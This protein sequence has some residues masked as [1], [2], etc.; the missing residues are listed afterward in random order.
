[1]SGAGNNDDPPAHS[2]PVPPAAPASGAR[3]D[4]RADAIIVL[5]GG[6]HADGSL[7]RPSATRIERAAEIFH[8]GIAPRIILSGR[9]GLAAPEP[10]ITE[11]AAMAARAEELGV[12]AAALLLE[13]ESRD[14]IGNVYFTREMFLEPNG[15]HSVR[16][17][18]S[19]FHLSRAA[20]VFRKILGGSYDFSFV[21]ASSGLSPR[22]L[23]FRSLEECKLSIFL[24]E[25]LEALHDAD[26]HAIDRL[27]ENDHPGYASAPTLS[28]DEMRRRLDEIAHINE[29]A[30]TEHWLAGDRRG[31]PRRGDRRER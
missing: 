21:S 1:V 23:I 24:N 29:I 25:W 19:D 9:C 5:G 6:V 20:W 26:E 8:G 17:V 11:A 3:R 30:G 31:R 22:E 10:A 12:P 27:I 14:T 16:V 4:H 15:W 18:T 13:E 28:H 2:E 7:T